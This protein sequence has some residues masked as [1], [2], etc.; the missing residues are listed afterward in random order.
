MG[1]SLKDDDP[2]SYIISGLHPTYTTIVIL[3]VH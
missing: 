3:V 2:I 1:K